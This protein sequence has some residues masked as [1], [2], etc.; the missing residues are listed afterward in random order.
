MTTQPQ[1]DEE[2]AAGDQT[3]DLAEVEVLSKVVAPQKPLG[4]TGL[5]RSVGY[6]N[7]EFLPALRGPKAS[8]IYREMLS[9]SPLIGASVTTIEMLLKNVAWEVEAPNDSESAKKAE[10]IVRESMEEM[11]TSWRDFIA[12]ALSFIWYGWAFFETTYVKRGKYIGWA[13]MSI[14]GQESLIR[15]VFDD[16]GRSVGMIQSAPPKYTFTTIPT[17]RGVHIRNRGRKRNPEG[18]SALRNAY[19]PWY[20]S[21][22]MMQVEAV[23]IERDLAGLP[24]MWVPADILRD[25]AKNQAKQK[26]LEQFT[27][28]VRSVRRDANEGLIL[29]LEYDTETKQKRYEFQLLTSGGG[30]QFDTDKIIQRYEQRMLQAM[31]TDFIMLGAS[32]PNGSYAMHLDKTGML[33]AALNGHANQ[34]AEALNRQAIPQLMA[35]NSIPKADWPK[36]VPSD[37]DA[38]DLGQLASFMGAMAGMGMQFFPDADME[39]FVRKSARMPEMTDEERTVRT[40]EKKKADVTRFL[41]VQQSLLEAKAAI[42]DRSA[43]EDTS[44][45]ISSNPELEAELQQ[46]QMSQQ[47]GG[48]QI[49]PTTGLPVATGPGGTPQ[50]PVG[51]AAAKEVAGGPPGAAGQKKAAAKPSGSAKK[52]PE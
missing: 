46:Q 7:E 38:P 26:Q 37:V 9:N 48:Q 2:L 24:V 35:L 5:N 19:E 43:Q 30:R 34:I 14:R 3:E 44:M 39:S 25:S 47:P 51:A 15:W 40:R 32:S 52:K 29:P 13:D 20:Y 17:S 16:Y 18:I 49:D 28:L 6:V 4:A 11:D 41:G 1:Y 10:E 33:R 36:I 23:G 12:E 22:R 21:K 42:R 31:M 8:Q 27:K 50:H 45:E